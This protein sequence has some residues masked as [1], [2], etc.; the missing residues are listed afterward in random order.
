MHQAI[1]NTLRVRS[2]YRI[3]EFYNGFGVLRY[4]VN[5]SVHSHQ[6][7]VIS[8]GQARKPEKKTKKLEFGVSPNML[9]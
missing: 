8:T 5:S 6:T 2:P 1:G 7:S 3:Q 9:L 4:A